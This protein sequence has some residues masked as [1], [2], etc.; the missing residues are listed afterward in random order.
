MKKTARLNVEYDPLHSAFSLVVESGSVLQVHSAET[1]EY[2]PDRSITPLVLTPYFNVVDVTGLTPSGRAESKLVDMRWYE[3]SEDDSNL[4]ISGMNGYTINGYKLTIAKNINYLSPITIIFTAKYFD[5]R[6]GK[7]LRLSDKKTLSTTSLTEKPVT[8]ELDKPESSWLF[9]PLHDTGLRSVT[10]TMR[11]AGNIVDAS[12][13]L[14]WWYKVVS[15]VET[16]VDPLDD[17]WYE[18][19]QNTSVL[20]IDPRYVDGNLHLRC[21]GEYVE[22]GKTAPTQPTSFCQMA[23]TTVVRR[24]SAYDF[25]FFINGGNQVSSDVEHIKAESIIRQGNDLISSPESFFLIEWLIKHVT[26]GATWKT[27]GYGPDITIAKSAYINGADIALDLHEK[28]SLKA[29]SIN[30]DVLTIND[31]IITL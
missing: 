11:L 16:L 14:Y 26:W 4:I 9:D 2:I 25:D 29:A 20:S 23:D 5:V 10:A 19:G 31:V 22:P 6:S 18:S 12:R 15:G 1:D 13:A 7:T 8:L 17:L 3:G 21:K 30:G 24:Y 28:E 27:L